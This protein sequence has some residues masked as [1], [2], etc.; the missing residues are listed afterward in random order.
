MKKL[1]L[2]ALMVI[3][4][5]GCTEEHHNSY[6]TYVSDYQKNYTIRSNQWT[7]AIDDDFGVYFY[8]QIGDQNLT[9]DVFKY[10]IMTA[11]LYYVQPTS[12]VTELHLLPFDDYYID[13]NGYKWTEQ[14]SCSFSPGYITFFLKYDDQ[15]HDTP[16]SDYTFQVRFLW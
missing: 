12:R 11:Y 3:F 1:S 9:Q 14:V 2:L 15:T 4:L 16:S 13:K 10:G 7:K 5:G 6:S 8:Y